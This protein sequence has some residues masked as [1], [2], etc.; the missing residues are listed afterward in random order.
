M[1]DGFEKNLEGHTDNDKNLEN[2]WK[3]HWNHRKT[4]DENLPEA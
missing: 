4:L 1:G 2:V 3:T